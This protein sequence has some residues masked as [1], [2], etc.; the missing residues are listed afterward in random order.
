MDS[1]F[2]D[3]LTLRVVHGLSP[4]EIAHTLNRKPGTVRMQLKRG[5]EELR[6]KLPMAISSVLVLAI[7]PERGLA[8]V[9]ARV[10]DIAA[11]G[12][13]PV[14]F[15]GMKAAAWFAIACLVIA[16]VSLP[17]V[18]SAADPKS[19]GQQKPIGAAAQR[20]AAVNEL[21][22]AESVT[23]TPVDEALAASEAV[24]SS[25]F[26]GRCVGSDLMTP[27]AGAQ[28]SVLFSAGRFVDED[29]QVWPDPVTVQTAADGRFAVEFV[30]RREMRV[31]LDIRAS[32]H[33]RT[34]ASWVS[35]RSG[36]DIQLGDVVLPPGGE[37][38]ARVCI[39]EVMFLPM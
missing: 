29:A 25:K 21:G 15:L 28:V 8:A 24:S 19:G 17:L 3:A 2:R 36:I 35:L 31:A 34:R 37:I 11:E 7:L 38:D 1:P 5:L 4:T 39:C 6:A 30:P 33:A 14:G 18:W 22:V 16:V 9:R 10:L 32:G 20:S 12:A 26:V 23:R 13:K 27:I